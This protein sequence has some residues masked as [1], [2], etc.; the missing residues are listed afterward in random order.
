[1]NISR[2]IACI[3][4]CAMMAIG[5][6]AAAQNTIAITEFMN[7]AYGDEAVEEWI[8]LCNFGTSP[9]NVNG[10][11]ISDDATADTA[12]L[13]NVTIAA[14]DFLILA[15]HKARFEAQWAFGQANAKVVSATG[16]WPAMGNTADELILRTAASVLVWRLGYANDD[17][18]GRAT[19]F[20]GTS[21]SQTDYGT[22]AA[23]GIVRNG[24]D[25][26]GGIGYQSND[27]TSDTVVYYCGKNPNQTNWGSPLRGH[28]GTPSTPARHV[29]DAKGTGTSFNPGVRGIALSDT[30]VDSIQTY[31]G[32]PGSL[33]ALAGSSTRG[34]AGGLYADLYD[35]RTRVSTYHG[36]YTDDTQ[37]RNTTLEFMRWAR[38]Y[39][40][41]L[42][43]TANSRGLVEYDPVTIG[44]VRYYTSDTLTL[45]NM[46][47]DWVHYTN[48]I[49]QTYRQGDTISDS[50]DQAIVNSLVWSSATPGDNF[51]KLLTPGEQ[52]VAKVKY[53]EIGNEP[54]ISVSG[55]VGVSNGFTMNAATYAARY[56]VIAQAMKAEDPTIKVG[57]CVV[58]GSGTRADHIIA[59]ASD[60]AIPIDF[61]AYHPYQDLGDVAGVAAQEYLSGVYNHQYDRWQDIRDALT[62]GGRNPNTIEMVA[63]E[64]NVSDWDYNETQK[65]GEMAHAI[66]SVETVFTYA[67]L[68]LIASH[69]WIWINDAEFGTKYPV[70]LAYEKMRDSMGNTLLDAY[71]D[72]SR[73][74]VYITRNSTNG[75]V[76][77]WA[78]NFQHADSTT[79][80]LAIQNASNSSVRRFTLKSLA[81]TTNLS[82]GNY[83]GNRPGGP[84]NEVNW[85]ETSLNGTNLGTLDLALEPATLTTV[86]FKIQTAATDW[87]LYE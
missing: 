8:E 25:T 75:D 43:V 80:S 84:R 81:G 72:G 5:G 58:D 77:V 71:T 82:A 47:A 14:G 86:L 70:T 29:I 57:P 11:K 22:K 37:A 56:K 23:P 39:K 30:P 46:A 50:R 9:V 3:F 20:A 10:W 66:G 15:R 42:F 76:A 7:E 35:W 60:P 52:A 16:S 26:G 54:T 55:G 73:V 34:V 13:P 28:Y 69:Y 78:L 2:T 38:D 33:N 83:S 17:T 59:L 51:N 40:A 21:F 18:G 53:W 41:E 74:R 49:V 87:P 31:V 61:I 65:E 44:K 85:V 1:M 6:P 36:S 48:Y 79:V 63:S 24:N 67:R 68:G 62:A 27:Y 32:I 19:F 12:I 64:V 4:T 45:A